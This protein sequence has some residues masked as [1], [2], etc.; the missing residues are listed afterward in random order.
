[1]T[2]HKAFWGDLDAGQTFK[3]ASDHALFWKQIQIGWKYSHVIQRVSEEQ[4]LQMFFLAEV[5][6]E[7]RKIWDWVYVLD[8]V[9]L[10]SMINK[11]LLYFYH[12]LPSAKSALTKD[13]TIWFQ[14]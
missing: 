8:D 14:T 12:A 13:M 7:P 1:M 10:V 4:M 9:K 11:C 2:F 5:F 6:R 3:A